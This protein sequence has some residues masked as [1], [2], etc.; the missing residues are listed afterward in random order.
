MTR[1]EPAGP[2][3]G[4]AAPAARQVDLPPGGA[5]RARWPRAATTVEN[6][7]DAAD[8]RSTLARRRGRRRRGRASDADG[9]RRLVVEID[10]VGLRGAAPGGQI[11]VGNAGTLL[12]L[13]PGLARR[14]GRRGVDA[15][16]RRVD[17]P[18]PGRPDRRAAAAG[19]ARDVEA[20]DGPP[21]AA[22][23][24]GRAAARDRLRAAGRQR[25]GE[26]VPAARRAA[27]RGR[28]PGRRAAADPRPH[29]AACCA[30][31][32][33]RDRGATASAD[34]GRARPSALEAGDDRGARR[35]LLG[36]LLHRRRAARAGQRGAARARS[37]STGPASAC[38]RSSRGW[39]SRWVRRRAE[40]AVR[41][42]DREPGRADRR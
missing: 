6:Y 37:A 7:L 2:L 24:R 19:W 13:L 31:A 34:H 28:R 8:T 29:R 23:R 16:R 33:R 14:A 20:R 3:R 4:D 22:A 9:R 35:L 18:P 21:A 5:V 26:V 32:G 41:R 27:R 30:A 15:R 39:A 11:D 25:P 1:F 10:G 40:A 36:R 17:P 38:S 42:G 12:R